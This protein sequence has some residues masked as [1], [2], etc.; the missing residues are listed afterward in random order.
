MARQ[1][2]ATDPST[3]AAAFNAQAQ[4]TACGKLL[5]NRVRPVGNGMPIRKPAGAIMHT[6][7][8]AFNGSGHPTPNSLTGAARYA[9]AETV[10]ATPASTALKRP[11]LLASPVKRRLE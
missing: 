9:S 10:T 11:V 3:L 7:T 4:R 6:V 1:I 5:S 8:R 2:A